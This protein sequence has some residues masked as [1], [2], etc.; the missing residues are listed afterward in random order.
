VIEELLVPDGGDALV[1]HHLLPGSRCR[2]DL[3]PQVLDQVAEAPCLAVA[4]VEAVE[5][6]EVLRIFG[7]HELVTPR[8]V[9][10]ILQIELRG[11]RDAEEGRGALFSLE[12]ARTRFEGLHEAGEVSGL[13][14]HRDQRFA[15]FL[16]GRIVLE[17][18]LVELAGGV[19]CRQLGLEELRGFHAQVAREW[20]RGLR[21]VGAYQERGAEL[22]PLLVL[23]VDVRDAFERAVVGG[24]ARQK[25]GVVRKSQIGA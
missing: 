7:D 12:G 11:L 21:C 18:A 22:A 24:V 2:C 3:L 6:V 8:G 19:A 25:L 4:P 9:D 13:L 14:V 17:H 23:A 16:V 5:R 20:R 1:Q 10:E 15:G